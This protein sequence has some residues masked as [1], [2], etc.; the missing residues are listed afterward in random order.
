MVSK[1]G[2]QELEQNASRYVQD[3]V[4]GMQFEITNRGHSTGVTL[5]RDTK[6]GRGATLEEIRG[7]WDTPISSEGRSELLRF[8]ESGRDSAGFINESKH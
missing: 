1:I 6:R 7:L 5:S 3:A 2:V 4:M 8:V